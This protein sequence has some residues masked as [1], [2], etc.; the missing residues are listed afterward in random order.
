ML[1]NTQ[2]AE[3]IKQKRKQYEAAFY[4]RQIDVA[5]AKAVDDERMEEQ[6]KEQMKQ[7]QRQMDALDKVL[8][9]LQSGDKD[10]E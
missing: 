8:E 9:E 4:S 2:R 10:I 7:I 5:V 6:A 3:I 1:N